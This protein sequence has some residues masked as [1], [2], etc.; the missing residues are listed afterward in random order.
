MNSYLT[1]QM[2]IPSSR[3]GYNGRL[4]LADCVGIF[5]DIASAHAHDLGMS[6]DAMLAK[7]CY[8][9]CAKTR[10][11]FYDMPKIMDNAVLTTW[12][13]PTERFSANRDYE[14]TAED[15][16]VMAAGK[17]QWAVVSTENGKLV[18]TAEV[19]P[20]GLQYL[21]KLACPEP[22]ARI[23]DKFEGDSFAAYKVLSTDIDIN[24]HMNN[25]KYFTAFF[26]LFSI[27]EIEAMNIRTMEVQYKTPCYE[28]DV[29]HFFKRNMEDGGTEYKAALED[30]K[31]IAL[32]R[33]N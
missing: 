23:R 31:T 2:N 3:C 5:L 12:P 22:F 32:F 17:T 27:E 6:E 10:I 18:Q 30:G 33:I 26:S 8:W 15:G 29:L 11:N 25:A 4:G 24:R 9:V 28:G 13:E 7:N 20:M 14:L 21:E 1:Q 16:T 19:F